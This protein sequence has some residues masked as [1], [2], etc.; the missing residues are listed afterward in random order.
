MWRYAVRMRI[1]EDDPIVVALTK[2]YVLGTIIYGVLVGIAF[3]GA[4]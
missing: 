1:V 2:Q 3:I 4:E